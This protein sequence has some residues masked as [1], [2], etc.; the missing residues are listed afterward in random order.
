M[1]MRIYINLK[2]KTLKILESENLPSIAE[3]KLEIENET[4]EHNDSS[5][6]K[7]DRKTRKVEVLQ[8][9]EFKSTLCK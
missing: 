9:S 8:S 2:L 5:I 7:T 6:N 4:I 1:I 3:D